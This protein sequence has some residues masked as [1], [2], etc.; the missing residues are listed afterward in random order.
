MDSSV[1][2]SVSEARKFGEILRDH[3][4]TVRTADEMLVFLYRFRDRL[5]HSGVRSSLI[6]RLNESVHDLEAD[7]DGT[8]NGLESREL[9]QALMED[10]AGG[11][12]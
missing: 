11:R 8:L 2:N 6:S 4:E 10:V 1:A 12:K 5:M 3:R 7:P 9:L